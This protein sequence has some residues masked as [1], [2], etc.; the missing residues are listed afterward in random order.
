MGGPRCPQPPGPHAG[1]HRLRHGSCTRGTAQAAAPTCGI[2]SP[3]ACGS[4]APCG[5]VGCTPRGH[6]PTATSTSAIRAALSWRLRRPPKEVTTKETGPALSCGHAACSPKRPAQRLPHKRLAHSS[7]PALGSVLPQ[8][9]GLNPPSGEGQSR[10]LA[11]RAPSLGLGR[12]DACSWRPPPPP[13]GLR[14]AS[15]GLGHKVAADHCPCWGSSAR[16]GTP[17]ARGQTR[18]PAPWVGP[19]TTNPAARIHLTPGNVLV[20]RAESAV[21]CFAH[22]LFS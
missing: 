12:S 5:A 18:A 17:Q 14:A 9:T 20:L 2:I 13:P 1:R 11:H 6:S 10:T 8:A 21:L 4:S 19:Q 15:G 16:T 22:L 7:G 3:Q